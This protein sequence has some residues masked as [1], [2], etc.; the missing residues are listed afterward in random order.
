[1]LA[2]PWPWF[3][4]QAW[5]EDPGA[6]LHVKSPAKALDGNRALGPAARAAAEAWEA[7]FLELAGGE[8]ARMAAAAGLALSYSAERSVQDELARES[9]A[10]LGT[11]RGPGR[12]GRCVAAAQVDRGE[13]PQGPLG[14]ARLALAQRE[15]CNCAQR[16]WCERAC[17]ILGA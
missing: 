1:M 17:S 4:C 12:P 11:A 13:L 16:V 15:G 6:S 8:L 5:T 9:F 14:T 2:A 7:A 10:D 3:A